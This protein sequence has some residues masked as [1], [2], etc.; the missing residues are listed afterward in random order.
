MTSAVVAQAHF[1][2]VR[3]PYVPAFAQR[4]ALALGAPLGRALG[5]EP[6]YVPAGD[7]VYAV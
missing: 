4:A 2:T 1:D 7:A 6:T 3:L 5:Y